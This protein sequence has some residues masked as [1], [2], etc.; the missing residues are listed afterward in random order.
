MSLLDM[1][2]YGNCSGVQFRIWP[3]WGLNAR[4]SY[5]KAGRLWLWL[6][7]CKLVLRLEGEPLHCLQAWPGTDQVRYGSHLA[8][9]RRASWE[10][11]LPPVMP[12]LSQLV[13]EVAMHPLLLS[14]H[15]TWQLCRAESWQSGELS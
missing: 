7:I 8:C 9:T 14:G 3:L 2:V 6:R 10:A 5:V 4:C 1:W 15:G 13:S 11:A 12:I